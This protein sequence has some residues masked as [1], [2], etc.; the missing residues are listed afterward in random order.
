MEKKNIEILSP[1]NQLQLYGY[2]KYFDLFIN[3]FKKNKLPNTIL[4]SGIKG[5]GK[6]TF[7]YHFINYLLSLNEVEKYLLAIR[8]SDK[9]QKENSIGG[10][11]Y[12]KKDF[13][14]KKK[15]I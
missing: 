1:R 6:S 5:L 9:T 2:N 12:Y 3:L 4:L 8:N 10:R 7:A 11:K 15:R 14:L 13:H